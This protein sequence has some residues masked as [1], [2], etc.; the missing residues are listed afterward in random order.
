MGGVPGWYR[1]GMT[2]SK[3]GGHLTAWR[4]SIPQRGPWH[5]IFGRGG[6]ER[7]GNKSL[8]GGNQRAS[9]RPTQIERRRNRLFFRAK[10]EGHGKTGKKPRNPA[11]AKPTNSFKQK[12]TFLQKSGDRGK[13][14]CV[15]WG[16]TK[17]QGKE[18]DAGGERTMGAPRGK[19]R[20]HYLPSPA[21]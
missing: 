10:K 19:P 11:L 12:T 8:N 21:K 6:T 5:K 1:E 18:R 20:D 16:K 3:G 7:G 17:K 15:R 13:R 9:G 2:K 4:Q 14:G